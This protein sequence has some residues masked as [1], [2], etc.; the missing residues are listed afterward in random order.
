[1]IVSRRPWTL[2]DVDL[3]GAGGM[4][5]L[6]LLAWWL[7]AAPWQAMWR[8][9][10][11]LAAARTAAQTRLQQAGLELRGYE[12]RLAELAQTV[13]TQTRAV[14]AADELSRQ[15]R[16]MT[17]TAGATQLAVL[18]VTPQPAA[19]DGAYWVSDVQFGGRGQSQ[20]FIRFLDRLAQENPYQALRTCSI[21][22]NGAADQPLCDLNW[23]V[24]MYLV[25]RTAEGGRP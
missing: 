13:T 12:E 4:L 20:D 18:S 16:R 22:H 11:A 14:P 21:T 7:V 23:T 24:R 17:D 15:L 8:D 9:Y 2:Y 1:M 19:L 10:R 6:A 3:L 5:A 25:P